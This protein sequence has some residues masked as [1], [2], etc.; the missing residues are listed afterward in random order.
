LSGLVVAKI[1]RRFLIALASV[2]ILLSLSGSSPARA[3]GAAQPTKEQLTIQPKDD[4]DL[5]YHWEDPKYGREEWKQII[6]AAVFLGLVWAA[7]QAR[8]KALRARAR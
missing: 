6:G 3:D 2:A 7:S 4:G 8:A 5:V 1:K